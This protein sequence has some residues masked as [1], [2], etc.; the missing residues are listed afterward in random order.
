M[1]FTAIKENNCNGCFAAIKDHDHDQERRC[2]K[3]VKFDTHPVYRPGTECPYLAIKDLLESSKYGISIIEA[4]HEACSI[5]SA[6][7]EI[8]RETITRIEKMETR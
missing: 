4:E 7:Q 2:Q 5:Y 3:S 6:H 8:I 1:D